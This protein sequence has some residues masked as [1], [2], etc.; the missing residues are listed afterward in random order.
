M[1]QTV[2]IYTA[3]PSCAF[4]V[5]TSGRADRVG[6][7]HDRIDPAIY[8]DGTVTLT[9]TVTPAMLG[10]LTQAGCTTA[11][12]N[13]WFSIRE[14]VQNPPVNNVLNFNVAVLG[15]PPHLTP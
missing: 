11:T 10:C 9:F 6:A 14:T 4:P 2:P 12:N 3:S 5:N 7:P 15:L 13:G 8:G 1:N